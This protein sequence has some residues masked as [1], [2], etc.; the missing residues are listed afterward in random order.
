MFHHQSTKRAIL[1]SCPCSSIS[2]QGVQ[3]LPSVWIT[4]LQSV[5]ELCWSV[6]SNSNNSVLKG[7]GRGNSHQNITVVMPYEVDM[8][9]SDDWRE[10]LCFKAIFSFGTIKLAFKFMSF[11][12]SLLEYIIKILRFCNLFNRK[13]YTLESKHNKRRHIISSIM[14]LKLLKHLFFP[15]YY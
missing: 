12:F 14:N 15:I 11:L 1:K 2:L 9:F 4:V 10:K 8:V 3:N 5:Y 13:M 7:R 6:S